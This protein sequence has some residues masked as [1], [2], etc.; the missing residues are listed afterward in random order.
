LDFEILESVSSYPYWSANL[1]GSIG[2]FP[3][4]HLEKRE[5]K[6]PILGYVIKVWS[7]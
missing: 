3:E 6:C 4:I 2:L 5:N 1:Y 7:G